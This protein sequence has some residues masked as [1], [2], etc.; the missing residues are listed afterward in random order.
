M[1]DYSQICGSRNGDLGQVIEESIHQEKDEDL[2]RAT[3]AALEQVLISGLK[4]YFIRDPNLEEELFGKTAPLGALNAKIILSYYLGFLSEKE[5]KDLRLIDEIKNEF[6]AT[7]RSKTLSESEN[8]RSPILQ[9]GGSPRDSF[10]AAY[11][12]LAT[13]LLDRPK[14]YSTSKDKP[15][16]RDL[17]A[18]RLKALDKTMQRQMEDAAKNISTEEMQHIMSEQRERMKQDGMNIEEMQAMRMRMQTIQEE[19]GNK[20]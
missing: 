2:V 17:V 20:P 1:K 8:R 4:S 13:D 10:I 3:T 7:A 18:E 15:Y 14:Y 12:K 16:E 11:H 6:E 19:R 9:S 5:Y